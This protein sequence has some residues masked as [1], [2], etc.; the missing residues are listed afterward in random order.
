MAKLAPIE[1][2]L[3]ALVTPFRD[4][5][6]DF[7]GIA[8][9]VDWQIEQGV[10]GIVAV[11]TTGESATLDVDEHVAVIAAVVK[12]SKGRVPV[13]AGAG[14]NATSE[15]LALTK[16][17]EDAGADAL[18]HVTPYYNRPSQEGLFRHFEAVAKSTKLPVILYNVPS[19]TACDMT[20]ETVVRLADLPNVV[21]IKDAT[22]N[23]VRGSDLI[24][25]VGDRMAI[26]SGDDGT[27]FPLYAC[28]A[29]GVISVVSNVAPRA[30]SDMWDAVK[31]GDWDRAK[32]RH[33]ELRVLNAMLFAEPSP[34]PTKAALSLLGRCST[35]VRL[36]LVPAT[37]GLVEQL[38]TEMKSAGML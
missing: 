32:K 22:G 14:G 35:E 1:G 2:C 24:A 34:A 11:G 25:K 21:A 4:G 27:A 23:L 18:L 26:L 28:G 16:A 37:A 6:V 9:L 17:S 3:T 13:I 29:R 15:A 10:D 19:R 38:R 8:K 36:P 20:T 33:Y 7:D 5:K 31:A 12:A 30:M